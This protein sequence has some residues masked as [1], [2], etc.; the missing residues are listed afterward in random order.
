MFTPIHREL[1]LPS[2]YPLNWS[3]MEKVVAE[4]LSEKRDLDF[5]IGLYNSNDSNVNDE[6]AK[7]LCAMANSG[8]GWIICGVR[9]DSVTD[10]AMELTPFSV[11][12]NS[13][14]NLHRVARSSVQPPLMDIKIHPIKSPDER[15]IYAIEIPVTEV[16]PHL[17]LYKKGN[18]KYPFYAPIRNGASTIGLTEPEL[19][20]MYRESFLSLKERSE[21]ERNLYEEFSEYGEFYEG[22]TYVLVAIPEVLRTQRQEKQ[23]ILDVFCN[24]DA[25]MFRRSEFKYKPS[26]LNR[27][28]NTP[29]RRGY[30][31]WVIHNE[32]EVGEHYKWRVEIADNGIIR[33]A[34]KLSGKEV[35]EEAQDDSSLGIFNQAPQPLIENALIESFS[36]VIQSQTHWYPCNYKIRT[37]LSGIKSVPLVIR[38]TD[39]FNRSQ[40]RPEKES[41]QII[42]FKPVDGFLEQ[43]GNYQQNLQVLYQLAEDIVNQGEITYPEVVMSH[44]N[45]ITK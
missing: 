13:E 14:I 23:F 20:R 1:G 37:G 15:Y 26:L 38:R 12:K 22:L 2:S 31:S 27:Y 5:K 4:N 36:V 16:S 21:N 28:A 9:T 34:I 8:G 39:Q 32:N 11:D 42:H 41:K 33:C 45:R 6:I 29:I 40:V 18:D 10:C 3:L 7:D 44:E 43:T 25:D 30:R 35:R 17:C 19:R 24:R